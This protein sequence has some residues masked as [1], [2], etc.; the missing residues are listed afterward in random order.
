MKGLSVNHLISLYDLSR[1]E[2]QKIFKRTAELKK[3]PK[4]GKKLLKDKTL[5]MLFEKP[6]TRTRVSFETAM[7]Q[8]GGHAQYIDATTTQLGR[9]ETIADTARVLSRYVDGIM[10]RVNNHNTLLDFA[11]NSEI[12]IING[13]SD[14]NHPVQAISDLFTILEKKGKLAGLKLGWVGDATN[15]CHSLMYACGKLDVD[16]WIATPN[17]FR[18]ND[19]V[20]IEADK[21]S[22]A[23]TEY[24]TDAFEA[25]SKADVVYTDTWKSMGGKLPPIKKKALLKYQ[26]NKE[27]M[28]FAKKDYMFMHCLPAHRGEEVTANV[29]DSPNSIIYDQAENRLHVQKAIL[30]LML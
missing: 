13:L 20:R 21:L 3:K 14:F 22:L 25:V 17:F 23:A 9:G 15:V 29:I 30:S 11:I 4:K 27:L 7:T 12:P 19:G 18:P 1:E 24:T 6:S 26:A 28:K 16:M 5:T 10:A 2:F 8:L